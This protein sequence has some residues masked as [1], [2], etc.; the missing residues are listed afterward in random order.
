LGRWAGER[1]GV[2]KVGVTRNGDPEGFKERVVGRQV[3][4]KKRVADAGLR[5]RDRK[6]SRHGK[7]GGDA[8][9]NGVGVGAAAVAAEEGDEDI[10]MNGVGDKLPARPVSTKK[11]A[12]A[13]RLPVLSIGTAAVTTAA[14]AARP[15]P[16]LD[17]IDQS[18]LAERSDEDMED[19]EGDG[20]G[21]ADGDGNG[22]EGSAEE[23]Y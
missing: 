18:L 7:G 19:G 6:P 4:R 21:D 17:D 10:T 12:N 13:S 1:D 2:G 14:T 15:V 5:D 9:K 16:G 23:F 11:K 3:G 22:D 8:R 20:D